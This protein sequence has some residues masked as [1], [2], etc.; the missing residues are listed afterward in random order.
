MNNLL[1]TIQA[2][3]MKVPKP[4]RNKYVL[5]LIVFV[6]WMV[7]FDKHDVVTQVKLQSTVESLQEKKTFYETNIEKAEQDLTDLELNGEKFARERYFMH[8][9]KEDVY[10]IQ[11][12][13]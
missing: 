8:K 2:I 7:F 4:I 5:T 9:A 1:N 6:S 13:E 10:I 3:W 11:E 12:V